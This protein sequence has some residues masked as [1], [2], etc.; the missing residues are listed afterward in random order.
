MEVYSFALIDEAFTCVSEGYADAA[1][2]HESTLDYFAKHSPRAWRRLPGSLAVVD[3]GVAFD[4]R[5]DSAF[6]RRLSETLAGFRQ[7]GTLL[8]ILKKYAY[9]EPDDRSI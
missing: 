7:D 8:T 5:A 4:H 3:V 6:V 9:V 2:S 1:A